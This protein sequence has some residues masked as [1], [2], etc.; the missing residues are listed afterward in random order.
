MFRQI[1]VLILLFSFSAQV[2]S[3]ATIIMDYYANTTAYS[4]KCE[5]KARPQMH[6]KG[7]CQMMKKLK[8]EEK[9][10]QEAP[11]RKAE[12]KIEVLSSKSF[13]THLSIEKTHITSRYSSF[14]L[15]SL[16]METPGSVFHPPASC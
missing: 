2:F 8:E 14:Y 11:C 7:K 9:K 16:P 12:L 6:C 4:K 10:E 15:I 3:Q 1:T 5:N 13:F